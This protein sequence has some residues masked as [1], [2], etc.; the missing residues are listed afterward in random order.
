MICPK[1]R[2]FIPQSQELLWPDT[3][4]ATRALPYRTRFEDLPG[5]RYDASAASH[6][7]LR[8]PLRAIAAPV[9]AP[10]REITRD[11]RS[12][13]VIQSNRLRKGAAL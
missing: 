13:A 2:S 12:L 7:F 6:C 10:A 11:W 9:A 4:I 1:H 5:Q 3:R 8:L